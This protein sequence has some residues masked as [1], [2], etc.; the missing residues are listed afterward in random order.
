MP[1]RVAYA[2]QQIGAKLSF[3]GNDP[4]LPLIEWKERQDRNT[5][6]GRIHILVVVNRVL[7]TGTLWYPV[8]WMYPKNYLMK[9]DY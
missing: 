9:N 8:P 7:W 2:Q 4:V 1:S 3:G 5:V 6:Q